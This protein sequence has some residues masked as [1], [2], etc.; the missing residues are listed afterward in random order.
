MPCQCSVVLWFPLPTDSRLRNFFALSL[1]CICILYRP[2]GTQCFFLNLDLHLDRL[3]TNT[4]RPMLLTHTG[5]YDRLRLPATCSVSERAP[6]VNASGGKPHQMSLCLYCGEHNPPRLLSRSLLPSIIAT[7]PFSRIFTLRFLP[8]M[9]TNVRPT[10][11]K[12]KYV[13]AQ[14]T[15]KSLNIRS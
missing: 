10:F 15:R 9:M 1:F 14:F 7:K 5:S 3:C 12:H 6:K 4:F 2:D 11:G 8:V 13:L